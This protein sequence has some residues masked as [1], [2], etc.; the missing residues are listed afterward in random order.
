MEDIFRDIDADYYG[1]INGDILIGAQLFSLLDK[2][3]SLIESGTIS[4]IVASL[5][6]LDP[7]VHLR[8]LHVILL[9][10]IY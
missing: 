6:V 3:D 2:I 10:Q 9:F 5:G 8:V 1:I 7:S 4:K